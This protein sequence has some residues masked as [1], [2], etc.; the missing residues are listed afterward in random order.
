MITTAPGSAPPADPFTRFSREPVWARVVHHENL[1]ALHRR[2]QLV[3]AGLLDDPR[4]ADLHFPGQRR[5]LEALRVT[6]DAELAR[7]AAVPTALFTLPLRIDLPDLQ[8]FRRFV[9]RDA[10]EAASIEE[11]FLGLLNRLDAL[12]ADPARARLYFDLSRTEAEWLVALTPPE[13]EVLARDPLLR[14]QSAVGGD[15]F[16]IVLAGDQ[17]D[18]R[19][20]VLGAAGRAR[21]V[22]GWA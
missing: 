20:R 16:D 15:F 7:M 2:R 8:S 3:L 5:L 14:L 22:M 9:P 12:R 6:T 17:D 19:L 10:L 1:R 18:A 11:T 13:L 4:E 21:S